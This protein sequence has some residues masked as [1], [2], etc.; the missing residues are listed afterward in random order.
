MVW[1]EANEPGRATERVHLRLASDD[2][3]WCAER[4]RQ[5]APVT[6]IYISGICPIAELAPAASPAVVLVDAGTDLAA[7]LEAVAP[8]TRQDA[9][10]VFVLVL[11]SGQPAEVYPQAA[12][13]GVRLV[14]GS[15]PDLPQLTESIYGAAAHLGPGHAGAPLSEA[16]QHVHA[17]F[18]T[19]GGVGRTTVAVNLAVAL[20][21][22]GLR[23]ALLDLHLDWG[24]VGTHLRVQAPRPYR[25]LLAETRHL[26][27]DLLLSFM[28]RHGPSLW[29][30]PAPAKPEVAEFVH[31]EHVRAVLAVAREGFE[32]VVLDTP[33][34][35]PETLLPALEDSDHLLMLTTPDVPTLRNTRAA[36]AVLDLL[37]LGR[38]KAHLVLNRANRGVG[39]RRSDVEATLGLPV[40]FELPAD[41]AAVLRAANEGVPVV[42]AAG[43]R[44]GSAIQALGRQL[45]PEERPATS[46]RERRSLPDIRARLTRG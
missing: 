35:F 43:S 42:E 2:T 36:L 31:A 23:T 34:G 11:R 40:W 37:Q 24:N 41:D 25:D 6:D 20:A 21:E 18:G 44:L 46:S 7:T 8:H 26:D 17:V 45:V 29:V 39:V 32:A 16:T 14:L 15:S 28:S 13:A 4:A 33:A 9:A 30:L 12:L 3:A 1:L 22:R 19:K 10:S 38:G 27:P 5:L